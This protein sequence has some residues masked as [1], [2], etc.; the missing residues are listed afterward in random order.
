MTI[1]GKYEIISISTFIKRYSI[2][3]ITTKY[4]HVGGLLVL[5][6][7]LEILFIGVL[8]LFIIRLKES[9]DMVEC[10]FS[11]KEIFTID[12]H[13]MRTWE[14]VLALDNGIE[15]VTVSYEKL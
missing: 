10:F 12:L 1:K 7:K 15:N 4:I 2:L 8:F 14:A 9:V 5:S 13:N 3:I 6:I 11:E